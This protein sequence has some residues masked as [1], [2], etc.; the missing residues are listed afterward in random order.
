MLQQSMLGFTTPLRYA[1][2]LAGVWL[3]AC[4]SPSSSPTNHAA[5]TTNSADSTAASAPVAPANSPLQVVAQFREPQIVGVAVTPDGR[6]FGDFPRWDNNPVNPV[7]EIM[8]DGSVKGYPDANWN[9]WNETVRNEPQKHWICPQ[10]VHVDK[11]GMLWVLDPAS[12]GIKGTVPGGPKLVKIDPKT[13]KVVQNIS[14]PESV[15]SR[16]SYLND[17]RVDTQNQYAYITESGVG[18]LVVVDLKSGKSRK[19]LAQHASMMADTTLNIK[20]DG[21]ELIDPSGNKARFNADGIA[22]SQDLQ[23][24]YWKPLTSYKLYRI[25]TEALRN[26]A[27][28]DAQ[29]A[30]QIED[31]GKV[32][33]CD[34]MEIDAANN[35]Y[36]TAFED[37]SIKRRT[38]DGKVEMVVQDP[39][40]E[41]PD[42]FAFSADGKTLYITNSAIHKTP[43]WNKG[44]GKQDQPYHIFKMALAK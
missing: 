10:S 17:V 38:P 28:S 31:L 39:R 24:L 7:A 19:L 3:S 16:K 42:T 37:H 35:V 8:P 2:L 30:Q 22:L 41:W 32:P 13:D 26:P 21:K 6:V 9:L 34:G 40:L 5:T 25:K 1:S 4:S 11:T 15:A 12:P 36:L 23:Y 33:A 20:A 44:I 29:L 27:L 43:T 18:S 14:I